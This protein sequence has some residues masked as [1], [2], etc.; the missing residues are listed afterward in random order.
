MH[1]SLA[2]PYIAGYFQTSEITVAI[3]AVNSVHGKINHVF[4]YMASG[5]KFS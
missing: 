2:A 4:A 1:V 5:C 3:I